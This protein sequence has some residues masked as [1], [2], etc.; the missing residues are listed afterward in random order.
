MKKTLCKR[1][2][3]VLT[4]ILI[5]YMFGTSVYGANINKMS[6][7]EAA[8]L[9]DMYGENN[10]K[11]DEN[12]EENAKRTAEKLK[13]AEK[14]MK[15]ID[16]MDK[17]ELDETEEMRSNLGDDIM[18][19]FGDDRSIAATLYYVY[20]PYHAQETSY[21]C[22][23]AT[24]QQ[25]IDSW[26]Y[27]DHYDG[28]L[29]SQDD[30]ADD[31]DTTTSGTNIY[32]YRD[33]LN[34]YL[35]DYYVTTFIKDSSDKDMLEIAT[36]YGA[37]NDKA[38]TYLVVKNL[39]KYYSGTSSSGHYISGNGMWDYGSFDDDTVLL[40]DCNSNPTYGGLH[41]VGFNELHAALVE[42]YDTRGVANL[43]W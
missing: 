26:I 37:N 38:V 28:D 34:E 41:E 14:L 36:K 22:G 16:S 7:E 20:V 6:D 11:P 40:E 27:Y 13:D 21:W 23:P 1:F 18:R 5:V 8:M 29:P 25:T 3:F 17:S 31:M 30:L 9:Y 4:A 10:V 24:G 19:Q 15:K 35:D 12:A 33:A 42:Y 32:D 39:L 43:V 2:S